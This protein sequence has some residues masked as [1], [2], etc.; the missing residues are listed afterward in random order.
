MIEKIKYL[1]FSNFDKNISSVT[2]SETD[3]LTEIYRTGELIDP[4]VVSGKILKVTPDTLTVE[5]QDEDG[6]VAV[7]N[8]TKYELLNS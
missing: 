6:D 8:V 3:D 4:N 1:D 2:D 5:T 7:V